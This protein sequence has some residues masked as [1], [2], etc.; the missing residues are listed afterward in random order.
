MVLVFVLVLSF[1][2]TAK[3]LYFVTYHYIFDKAIRK[4]DF[5]AVNYVIKI[6]ITVIREDF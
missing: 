5:L 3:C 6:E 1:Y 2:P 4:L